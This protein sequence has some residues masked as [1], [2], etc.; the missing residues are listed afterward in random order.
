MR[1]FAGKVAAI[2]GAGSGIG[3]ALAVELAQRGCHLAL[4]DVNEAGLGE[5]V[6]LLASSGVRVTHAR[7]DVA[8]REAVF[9]WADVVARE[10]GKVNLIFNNAG[11]A[12]GASIEDGRYEDLEWLMNIN[13]WGVVHGTKAFLPHLKATGDGHIVNTSSVFGLIAVPTQ[14]AYNAAKFAVRGFTEALRMELELSPCGVSAT[15]VHPG[16]IKTNIS[17]SARQDPSLAK[18]GIDPATA[19]AKFEKS[20]ITSAGD[21]ARIILRAVERDER[22][23]LVGPDARVIDWLARS[24]PSAYQKIVMFWS[25]RTMS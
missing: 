13:F 11:V 15:S 12:L 8:D 2:T 6:G 4:S 7:V 21:A 9:A 25:R 1:S 14:S 5:T 10:H 17:R 23:V 20:F 24:L 16:G 19:G 22:R 18:L 3:R